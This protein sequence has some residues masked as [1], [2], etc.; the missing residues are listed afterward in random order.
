MCDEV[1]KYAMKSVQEMVKND[2]KSKPPRIIIPQCVLDFVYENEIKPLWDSGN[3]EN[4]LI[5]YKT[6][7]VSITPVH[8]IRCI[9]VDIDIEEE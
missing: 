2:F 5:D 4:F 1:I 7:Y 6:G 3:L 8:K 9:K